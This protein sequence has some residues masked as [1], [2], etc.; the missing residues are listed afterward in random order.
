MLGRSMRE[1]WT[2]MTYTR[3]SFTE[4]SSPFCALAIRNIYQDIKCWFLGPIPL[5]LSRLPH[6]P[7]LL[8]KE[9][10]A[11]L[12]KARAED[13]GLTEL[14]ECRVAAR[15]WCRAVARVINPFLENPRALSVPHVLA[16]WDLDSIAFFPLRKV[17]GVLPVSL[18]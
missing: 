10:S 11:T 5:R 16:S 7:A 13:V 12:I 14:S 18:N 6:I 1:G 9:R 2:F 8:A 17:V 4:L 3:L 15:C